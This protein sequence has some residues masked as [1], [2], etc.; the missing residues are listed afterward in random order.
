MTATDYATQQAR[1]DILAWVQ[2]T[3]RQ[4]AIQRHKVQTRNRANLRM[5]ASDAR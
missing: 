1:H 5:F 3:E 4:E 2:R